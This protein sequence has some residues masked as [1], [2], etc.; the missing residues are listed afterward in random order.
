MDLDWRGDRWHDGEK[1]DQA[2]DERKTSEHAVS[3]A[4]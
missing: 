3:F 2:E 1:S 4:G